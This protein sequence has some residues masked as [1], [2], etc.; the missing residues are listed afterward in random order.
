MKQFKMQALAHKQ[1]AALADLAAAQNAA[2]KA[3]SAAAQAQANIRGYG[4]GH[5]H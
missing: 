2:N 5:G 1:Q 3:A 4:H